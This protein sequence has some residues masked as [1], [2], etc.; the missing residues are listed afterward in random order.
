MHVSLTLR[1][2]PPRR[3][4]VDL[5]AKFFLVKLDNDDAIPLNRATYPQCDR[6]AVDNPFATCERALHIAPSLCINNNQPRRAGEPLI[7]TATGSP[8]TIFCATTAGFAPLHICKPLR[9]HFRYSQVFSRETT[10]V[11]QFGP[12]STFV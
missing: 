2:S 5:Q 7:Y 6:S 12:P 9:L 1:R 4:F 8:L 11:P 10:K 3:H